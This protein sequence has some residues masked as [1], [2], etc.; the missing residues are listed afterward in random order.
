MRRT[1]LIVAF[2]SGTALCS[3]VLSKAQDLSRQMK[4][5][6]LEFKG[7]RLQEQQQAYFKYEIPKNDPKP[8]NTAMEYWSRW[9]IHRYGQSSV[10]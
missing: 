9:R 4:E 8:A 10:A 2:A 5:M 3:L 1:I 7:R 6:E